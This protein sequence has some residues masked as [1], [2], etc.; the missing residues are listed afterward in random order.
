MN[1]TV[2]WTVL[3]VAA[4][5]AM[6]GF[7]LQDARF[8]PS[9]PSGTGT[10]ISDGSIGVTVRENGEECLVRDRPVPCAEIGRHLRDVLKIPSD[11]PIVVSVEGTEDSTQRARRARQTL[12]ESGFSDVTSHAPAR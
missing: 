4:A 3:G 9:S 1:R 8:R 10:P 12:I 11:A 2:K 5:I 6:A 7:I